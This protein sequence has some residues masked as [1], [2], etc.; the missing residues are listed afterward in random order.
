MS[1]NK[2]SG[3]RV[4]GSWAAAGTQQKLPSKSVAKPVSA[5][6]V[7]RPTF[8]PSERVSRPLYLLISGRFIL[9]SFNTDCQA[10]F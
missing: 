1:V 3:T 6:D 4:R 8:Q 2:R 9:S 10:L 7:D 5:A